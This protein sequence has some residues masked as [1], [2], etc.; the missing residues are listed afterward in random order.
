MN[1]IILFIIVSLM[2][3]LNSGCQSL[4]KKFIR[5]E[6]KEEVPVYISP[7]EYPEKPT[8]EIYIDYYLYT[9]GWLDE[10]AKA[11]Q[12]GISYKRQ[13]RAIEEA[14]MNLDQIISFFNQE[15]KDN[16]LPLQSELKKIEEEIK[17]VPNLSRIKRDSLIREIQNIK[18]DFDSNYTYTDVK[19]WIN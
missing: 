6:K 16:I 9:K 12:K 18:R 13:K 17:R 4:R 10:L 3:V 8:R 5:K 7:K 14:V 2:L 19:E 15:G 1:R 11:L